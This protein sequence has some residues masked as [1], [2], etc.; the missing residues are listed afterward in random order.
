M[1]GIFYNNKGFM[2]LMDKAKNKKPDLLKV[3]QYRMDEEGPFKNEKEM[4]RSM[5]LIAE[6]AESLPLTLNDVKVKKDIIDMITRTDFWTGATADDLFKIRDELSSLM[7]YKQ[8]EPT[9]QIVIDM[10]DIIKQR[11]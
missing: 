10:G 2:K 4:Q 1:T 5:E 11:T 8:P 3:L 6:Y 9:P 7:Q